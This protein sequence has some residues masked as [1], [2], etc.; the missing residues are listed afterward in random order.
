MKSGSLKTAATLV[1]LGKLGLI[2]NE[3][4]R[5]V[6]REVMNLSYSPSSKSN[7]R[8]CWGQLWVYLVELLDIDV[9]LDGQSSFCVS[10][11][12]SGAITLVSLPQIAFSLLSSSVL[13]SHSD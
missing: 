13:S 2:L 9:L 6:L 7:L 11:V 12:D 8:W 1:W 3:L 4:G 10:V 5:S